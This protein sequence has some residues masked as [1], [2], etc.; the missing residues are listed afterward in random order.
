VDRRRP[1]SI[2]TDVRSRHFVIVRPRSEHT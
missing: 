2:E 1:P